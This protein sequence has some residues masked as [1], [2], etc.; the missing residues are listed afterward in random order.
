[1]S[2]LCLS[3]SQSHEV[4]EGLTGRPGDRYHMADDILTTSSRS[5]I[6]LQPTCSLDTVPPII[7]MPRTPT[8][9]TVKVESQPYPSSSP[10]SK[11]SD[12]KD[13]GSAKK[14]KAD[15]TG[16]KAS[17]WTVTVSSVIQYQIQTKI[18][19]RVQIHTGIQIQS[20][21]H[22]YS[23]GE[24]IKEDES[25]VLIPSWSESPSLDH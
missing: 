5:S 18:Q 7:K 17:V 6:R 10:T 9:A 2:R 15:R 23:D 16:E 1:M 3:T 21:T 19:S 11:S 22:T 25:E 13:G 24:T 8:K 20:R 4:M 14:V 12:S